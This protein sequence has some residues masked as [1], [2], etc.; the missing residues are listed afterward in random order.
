LKSSAVSTGFIQRRNNSPGCLG[1]A[2][3]IWETI[4]SG[5]LGKTNST[6]RGTSPCIPL[7]ADG[8]G[9][10]QKTAKDIVNKLGKNALGI[11]SKEGESCLTG[12]KGIGRKRGRRIVESVTSTFDLQEIISRLLVFGITANMAM[13]AYKEYGSNTVEMITKNPY[14]LTDFNL[15]D[16]QKADEIAR[17]IGIMP[18]SGYRIEACLKYVLKKLCFQDGHSYIPKGILMHETALALNH[19]ASEIVTEEELENSLLC[20]EEKFIV[21]E[22]GCIFPKFLHQHEERLAWKLSKMRGLR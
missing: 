19:N 1:N 12:V 22:D 21:N 18:V 7:I 2:P 11:I 20:S 8:K 3:E 5:R 4:K 15:V 14:K 16:F 9:M 17:K 6:N 13:K 10:W